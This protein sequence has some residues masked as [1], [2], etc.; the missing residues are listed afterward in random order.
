M[1][2]KCYISH[3]SRNPG[4]VWCLSWNACRVWV[5][6]CHTPKLFVQTPELYRLGTAVSEVVNH[7]EPLQSVKWGPLWALEILCRTKKGESKVGSP[8][9]RCHYRDIYWLVNY[10]IYSVSGVTTC[11]E[12][13]IPAIMES[14]LGQQELQ[15]SDFQ[16]TSGRCLLDSVNGHSLRFSCLSFPHIKFTFLRMKTLRLVAFSY[17]LPLLPWW[18]SHQG[19]NS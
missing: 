9:P 6:E 11:S 14:L 7:A 16:M 19:A 12:V 8:G 3:L 15:N 17:L 18:V 5:N 10:I 4:Q 13:L 2:G 1:Q